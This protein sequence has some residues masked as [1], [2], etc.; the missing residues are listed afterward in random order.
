MLACSHTFAHTHPHSSNPLASG[1]VLKLRVSVVN[2]T[3]RDSRPGLKAAARWRHSTHALC[4]G[5]HDTGKERNGNSAS[6]TARQRAARC[7]YTPPLAPTASCNLAS[8]SS[9][10]PGRNASAEHLSTQTYIYIRLRRYI[11]AWSTPKPTMMPQSS[12]SPCSSQ[13]RLTCTFIGPR[14]GTP[15]PTGV[16]SVDT[17]YPGFRP[18]TRHP[19]SRGRP[20]GRAELRGGPEVDAGPKWAAG[21]AAGNRTASGHRPHPPQHSGTPPPVPPRLCCNTHAQRLCCNTH[22]QR[23]A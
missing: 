13:S 2:H 7:Y 4:Q 8:R 18:G 12:W 16:R 19:W 20:Q 21:H 22:A 23:P 1:A 14:R 10:S 5:R 6:W 9:F 15:T 17:R 3:D 11:W